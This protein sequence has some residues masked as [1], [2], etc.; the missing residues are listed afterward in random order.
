MPSKPLGEF[1]R[2]GVITR[3]RLE[4]ERGHSYRLTPAG[5]ALGPVVLSL[6]TWSR[7]W[8]KRE[9]TAEDAD[10]ALLMWDMQRNLRLDRLP[11]DRVVAFFGFR[12]APDRK[13]SWWLVAEPS[14]TDLCITDP[15]FGVDL[16]IDAEAQAMAE[17]W[18][19]RL[20]LG[21]AMRS[22][23][24]RVRGP[25]HLIRSLPEWLG[26]SVFAHPDPVAGFAERH[27]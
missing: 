7:E 22:R 16:H 24:V 25:E 17:V 8:L 12:D 4:G 21:A 6:G 20:E 27:G 2:A 13:R 11:Q 3:H 26:L 10:P 19:G 9:V 5:E 23:K 1:E 18:I 14:G 15:G